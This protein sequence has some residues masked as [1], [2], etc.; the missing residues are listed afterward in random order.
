MDSA[1]QQEDGTEARLKALAQ[2]VISLHLRR[3]R[4]DA[5]CVG[6]VPH[7]HPQ[8]NTSN[9]IGLEQHLGCGICDWSMDGAP[10]SNLCLGPQSQISRLL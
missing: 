8:V 4:T 7:A 2:P 5:S 1:E 10:I 3:F 9:F 6:L